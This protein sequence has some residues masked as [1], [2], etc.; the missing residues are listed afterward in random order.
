MRDEEEITER[1]DY[2]YARLN[3]TSKTRVYGPDRDEFYGE[4]GALQ[5]VLGELEE[6][7]RVSEL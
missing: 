4:L 7:D 5:W 2:L 3:D 1:V 6:P